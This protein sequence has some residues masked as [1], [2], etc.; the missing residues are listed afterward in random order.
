MHN[1]FGSIETSEEAGVRYLHFGSEWVQGAMRIRKPNALELDYT[2]D[3]MACLLLKQESAWPQRVLQIGLGAASLTKFF[4][5][6]L[7]LSKIQIVEINPEVVPVARH[8][9][10][11]PSDPNRVRVEIADGVEYMQRRGRHFDL[12]MVDGFDADARPGKLDSPG[13]YESC[14]NRL[15]ND[16]LLAVNL[17]GRSRGHQASVKR[18]S[19]AFEKRAVAFPSNDDGNVIAF[20]ANG[21]AIE[22]PVTDLRK[23]ANAVKD[24]TGLNLLSVVSRLENSGLCKGKKFIL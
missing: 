10:Y 22:L 6:Y 13:F 7:P 14:R 8:H 11:L 20:A 5:H 21:R 15:T 2:R 9:F 17:L 16:G 3:M 12:I 18:I 19:D 4:Y 23:K 24:A 1:D